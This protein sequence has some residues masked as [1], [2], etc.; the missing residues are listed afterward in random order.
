MLDSV[1]GMGGRE[2]KTA[3]IRW[4]MAMALIFAVSFL[5]VF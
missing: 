1:Q 3:V 5:P 4:N 2:Q